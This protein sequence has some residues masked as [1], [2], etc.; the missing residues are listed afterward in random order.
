MMIIQR[1]GPILELGNPDRVQ[2]AT[3]RLVEIDSP[4]VIRFLYT[5][6]GC[7]ILFKNGERTF[8]HTAYYGSDQLPI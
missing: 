6:L 7:T 2:V 8:G 5:A 1:Y 4:I 3:G